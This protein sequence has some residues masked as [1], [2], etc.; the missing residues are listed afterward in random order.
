MEWIVLT[1]S[2]AVI[3]ILPWW[4][5]KVNV[6]PLSAAA[7]LGLGRAPL[8]SA[9]CLPHGHPSLPPLARPIPLS[10]PGLRRN[11]QAGAAAVNFVLGL[12]VVCRCGSVLVELCVI[13]RPVCVTVPETEPPRSGWFWERPRSPE[14]AESERRDAGTHRSHVGGP[15]RPTLVHLQGRLRAAG[16][17]R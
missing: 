13:G 3:L 17:Y 2:S 10:A 9:P 16:G 12:L 4:L 14:S 1:V 7:G 6:I 15:E 11:V 8:A 5:H